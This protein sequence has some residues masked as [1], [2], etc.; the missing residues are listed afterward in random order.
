MYVRVGEKPGGESGA[1]V[2]LFCFV[3]L[4]V[5]EVHS[6]KKTEKQRKQRQVQG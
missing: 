2:I 5:S 1:V 3:F 6:K 4:S